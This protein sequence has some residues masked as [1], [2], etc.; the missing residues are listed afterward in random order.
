MHCKRMLWQI[1]KTSIIINM[2]E[3]F[4]FRNFKSGCG[5][6]SKKCV[7]KLCNPQILAQMELRTCKLVLKLC[8][9]IQD[10][11]AF[12]DQFPFHFT[13]FLLKKSSIVFMHAALQWVHHMIY[14]MTTKPRMEV[15][16]IFASYNPESVECCSRSAGP[17]QF[18]CGDF[19]SS[20]FQ[21]KSSSNGEIDFFHD[22]MNVLG[23]KM[24][25][26][27]VNIRNP[28]SGSQTKDWNF[29]RFCEIMC[30]R[31]ERNMNHSISYL[32]IF[33]LFLIKIL[34]IRLCRT[35]LF[36]ILFFIQSYYSLSENISFFILFFNKTPAVML[37]LPE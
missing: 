1:S 33:N 14:F 19:E 37:A 10:Q 3:M 2:K 23:M 31:L 4:L 17:I 6:F 25:N 35:S 5:W 15:N 21:K 27:S 24:L 7:S 36:G 32:Q 26:S 16:K 28:N 12:Q 29:I 22:L 30:P 11:A 8:T 13:N 9:K 34:W 18:L 20:N